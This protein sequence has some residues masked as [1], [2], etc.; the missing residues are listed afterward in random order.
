MKTLLN[1]SLLAMT[2]LLFIACTSSAPVLPDSPSFNQGK[3]D[4]CATATGDYMKN[5][6]MFKENSDYQN[7]WFYGRKHCNPSQAQ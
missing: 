7:G 3:K 4:G 2:S 5:S 6:E 1:L